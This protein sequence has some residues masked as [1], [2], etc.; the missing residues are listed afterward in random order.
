LQRQDCAFDDVLRR[1]IAA[2]GIE[3]DLH[4]GGKAFIR[5]EKE[6]GM[7]CRGAFC[8]KAKNDSAAPARE[9]G[10]LKE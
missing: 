6:R 8:I 5:C 1:V 4:A 3:R 9:R 2:H 10:R 7:G